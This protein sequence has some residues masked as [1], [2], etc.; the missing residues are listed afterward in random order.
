[1]SKSDYRMKLEAEYKK[2]AKKADAR[3]RALEVASREEH[4]KGALTYAYRTA[5]KDIEKYSGEGSS[6]FQTK[7]PENTK[8]LEA[9]IAD[10]NKFLAK[11]TSTK[12]GIKNT[13]I[14][15]AKSINKLIYEE[16]PALGKNRLSWQDI[17][18]FYENEDNKLNEADYGSGTVLMVLASLKKVGS[19]AKKIEAFTKEG[20]TRILSGDK[21][22]DEITKNLLENGVTIDSLY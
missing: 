8:T 3:L 14:E 21:R 12:R 1:M 16:N 20:S 6:R 18:D 19:D 7:A 13:Y 9:K 15:R 2:I 10:I 22:I 4:Y 5:M 17:A 11:Q